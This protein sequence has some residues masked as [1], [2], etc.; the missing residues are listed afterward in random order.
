MHNDE[1]ND[2]IVATKQFVHKNTRDML[3]YVELIT[4]IH[5]MF[6]INNTILQLL[7]PDVVKKT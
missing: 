3:H 7:L 6:F 5:G 1:E 2:L 4:G